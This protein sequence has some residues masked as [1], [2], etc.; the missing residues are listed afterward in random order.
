[1]T[2]DEIDRIRTEIPFSVG[3]PR[4]LIFP[5]KIEHITSPVQ[6]LLYIVN[7]DGGCYH[8][9]CSDCLLSPDGH[10]SCTSA[11]RVSLRIEMARRRLE[12]LD[13][14]DWLDA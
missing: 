5:D 4:N 10:H 8:I 1:M 3:L 11:D 6:Q 14:I 13:P 2:P 12:N 7:H 9:R